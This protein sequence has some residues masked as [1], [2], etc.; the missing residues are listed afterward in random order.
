MNSIENDDSRATRRGASGKRSGGAF[1]TAR[2][3]KL[4]APPWGLLSSRVRAA[5]IA[6]ARSPASR[7][8]R[9]ARRASSAVDASTVITVHS[10]GGKLPARRQ[11]VSGLEKDHVQLAQSRLRPCAV[12]PEHRC[13]LD[14]VPAAR[15][16][17]IE[18]TRLAHQ[19]SSG[20]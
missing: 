8:A 4:A 9:K 11:H 14:Q 2:Q 7:P 5:R 6:V 12:L 19:H 1:S 15:E 3:M 17:R 16:C 10:L 18:E 20:L 13:K